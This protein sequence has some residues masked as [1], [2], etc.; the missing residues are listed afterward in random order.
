MCMSAYDR[1][2]YYRRK[3][4]DRRVD[5]GKDGRRAEFGSVIP[6]VDHDRNGKYIR[7]RQSQQPPQQEEKGQHTCNDYSHIPFSEVSS[8]GG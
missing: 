6:A 3:D 5:D 7:K 2:R 1:K 8:I 4:D